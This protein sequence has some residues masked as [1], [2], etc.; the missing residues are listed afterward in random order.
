MLHPLGRCDEIRI[1]NAVYGA[2]KDKRVC[3][4]PVEY[5]RVSEAKFKVHLFFALVTQCLCKLKIELLVFRSFFCARTGLSH[6]IGMDV[7]RSL[8]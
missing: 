6:D 5:P 2:T 4:H 8:V 3:Y 1:F 7:T